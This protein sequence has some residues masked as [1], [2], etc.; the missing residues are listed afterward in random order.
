M[1]LSYG[2][3]CRPEQTELTIPQVAI[4]ALVGGGV[5]IAA[6]REAN[7]AFGIKPIETVGVTPDGK[8]H[9]T[10]ELSPLG[11]GVDVIAALTFACAVRKL[12]GRLKGRSY[13]S[14]VST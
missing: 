4:S 2:E 8:S 12:A 6:G 9:I 5:G 10:S 14:K 7:E 3:G 13:Y 11:A 1:N